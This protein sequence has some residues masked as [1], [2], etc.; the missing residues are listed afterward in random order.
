MLD[1]MCTDVTSHPP[2]VLSLQQCN[3]L[4]VV[5]AALTVSGTAAAA[6]A[7]LQSAPSHYQQ[8]Q[9]QQRCIATGGI[10][11]PRAEC[12]DMARSRLTLCLALIVHPGKLTCMSH[13]NTAKSNIHLYSPL[14]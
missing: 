2:V 1:S 6:T 12:Y 5:A 11:G 9:Q 3:A 14:W 7:T 13:S 10:D 8:Q 4:P